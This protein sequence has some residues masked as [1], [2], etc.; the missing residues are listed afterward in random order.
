MR[1]MKA[2]KNRLVAGNIVYKLLADYTFC[3]IFN[4]LV[5]R[6][7]LTNVDIYLVT[8]TS[9]SRSDFECELNQVLSQ[10]KQL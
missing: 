8:F 1:R 7:Q 3:D 9:F 6:Q 4:Q 5:Q 10:I 2:F